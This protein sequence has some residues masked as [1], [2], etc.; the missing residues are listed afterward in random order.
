MHFPESLFLQPLLLQLLLADF[1]SALR[2][3]VAHGCCVSKTIK[4]IL[5]VSSPLEKMMGKQLISILFRIISGQVFLP[6]RA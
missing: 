3:F 5:Y 1:R 2:K 4:K 6:K